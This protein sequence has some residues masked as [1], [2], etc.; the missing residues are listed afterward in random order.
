[1]PMTKQQVMESRVFGADLCADPAMRFYYIDIP[2]NVR[3]QA[4][5]AHITHA[6]NFATADVWCAQ[7][8][9]GVVYVI[10]RGVVHG[11]AHELI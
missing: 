4:G 7:G 2:A 3:A 1:M 11:G 6:S 10:S 9:D 5:N 8:A